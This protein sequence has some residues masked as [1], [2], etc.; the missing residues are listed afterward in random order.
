MDRLCD[1]YQVSAGS[2]CLLCDN[3]LLKQ[4]IV[5][6]LL[7]ECTLFEPFPASFLFLVDVPLTCNHSACVASVFICMISLEGKGQVGIWACH[8]PLAIPVPCHCSDDG[9]IVA[10][11]GGFIA[12]L[13]SRSLSIA[14]VTSVTLELLWCTHFPTVTVGFNLQVYSLFGHW[15]LLTLVFIAAESTD[16]ILGQG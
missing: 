15:P 8:L 7:Y 9:H 16:R 5:N 4:V 11:D 12:L 2:A 13:I 6:V 10:C 3:S 1:A 14:H